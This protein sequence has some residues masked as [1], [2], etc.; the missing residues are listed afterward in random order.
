MMGMV[1][2]QVTEDNTHQ[3]I[4]QAKAKPVRP[5]LTPLNGAL[6]TGCRPN[7]TNTGYTLTY[8]LSGSNDSI[9]YGWNPQGVYTF[10]FYTASGHVTQTYQ[11][12]VQCSVP[13]TTSIPF[14]D[15]VE[16]NLLV[17]SENN[18]LIIRCLDA[19]LKR[20]VKRVFVAGMDGKE[21]YADS[22]LPENIDVSGFAKGAYV[23]HI[24]C[25]D[26]R[27]TEKFII[28]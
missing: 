25:R 16:K 15:R 28:R 18:V 9:I 26:R 14:K 19:E 17:T 1:M 21:M 8:T 22:M 2:G 3:L 20:S 6:I 7:G 4:P 10:D 5:S 12:F 27:I 24:V 23:L 11:G 13:V